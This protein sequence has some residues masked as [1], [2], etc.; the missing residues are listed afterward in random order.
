MSSD[1]QPLLNE[2]QQTVYETSRRSF[3]HS[4]QELKRFLSSKTG[5]YAVLGLVT[6]DVS[7]IFADFII[8]L[9]VCDTQKPAT[10]PANEAL[11]AL[12]ITGLVFST[13]FLVELIASVWAFGFRY[14]TTPFHAFDA[15]V[16]LAS[17]IVDTVL[18]GVAE[19]AASIVIILR[20]WRVFK[21]IEE[22]SV[23]ASE[24]MEGLR[25]KLAELEEE[26]AE[27]KRKG[28]MVGRDDGGEDEHGGVP[29]ITISQTV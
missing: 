15:I 6:L 5:H 24:Q 7:C 22:L 20:L 27:L 10:K 21:I 16:I 4:R 13:L 17:F 1:R 26:N 18:R 28:G 2:D 14:F 19:E 11:E 23:G 9:I 25:E 29:R 12:G 8:R 3:R